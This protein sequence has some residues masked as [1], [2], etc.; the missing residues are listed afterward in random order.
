[1]GEK[2]KEASQA[3]F[4][5]ITSNSYSHPWTWHFVF[6][7]IL[8]RWTSALNQSSEFLYSFGSPD[9]SHSIHYIINFCSMSCFYCC[10]SVFKG[11]ICLESHPSQ[12]SCFNTRVS[13]CSFDPPI[14]IFVS[15]SC[16]WWGIHQ[17]PPSMSLFMLT[18]THYPGTQA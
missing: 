18:S 6:A 1:M 14:Y 10:A 15:V 12:I 17:G 2:L 11:S 5:N 8:I 4:E 3:V 9:E 13:P 7:H 16:R